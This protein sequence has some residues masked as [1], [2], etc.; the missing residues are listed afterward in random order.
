ML[1][2]GKSHTGKVSKTVTQKEALATMDAGF[3]AIESAFKQGARTMDSVKQIAQMLR[4]LH[5]LNPAIPSVSFVTS[6]PSP[7]WQQKNILSKF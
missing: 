2:I 1:Q 3:E 6:K 7:C 4:K 5:S